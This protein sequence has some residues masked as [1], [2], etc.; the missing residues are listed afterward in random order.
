MISPTENIFRG[1]DNRFLGISFCSDSFTELGEAGKIAMT[2]RNNVLRG[3]ERFGKYMMS[4]SDY[5]RRR[6]R[7][8]PGGPTCNSFFYTSY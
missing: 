7:K 2:G 5:V 8:N 3:L 4:L 1:F 6:S